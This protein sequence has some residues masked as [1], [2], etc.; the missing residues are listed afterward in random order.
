MTTN[1]DDG[2]PMDI[3]YLDFA[4]AF[5]KGPHQPLIAKMKANGIGSNLIKWVEK[6]LNDR[7]Q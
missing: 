3:I 6:W 1:V 2:Q 7:T 5:D 4:K